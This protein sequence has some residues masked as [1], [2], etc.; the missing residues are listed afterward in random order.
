MGL[1]AKSILIDNYDY[2]FKI[3]LVA[4]NLTSFNHMCFKR[5]SAPGRSLQFFLKQ[6]NK[7]YLHYFE[8][9]GI[10]G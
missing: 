2:K 8:H 1:R 10:G 5:S 4:Y 9:Y 7:N 6:A 3:L